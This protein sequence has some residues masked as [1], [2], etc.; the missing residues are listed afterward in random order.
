MIRIGTGYDVH[1]L[2]EN[3]PLILGGVKIKYPLGLLGHSDADVLVHAIMDALLGA[4]ALGDI[5]KHFPDTDKAYKDCDS[6]LLLKKVAKLVNEKDYV[7]NNIDATIIAEKPKLAPHIQAMI[8]NIERT[9]NLSKNRVSVKVTT[10]EGLGFTGSQQGI[11]A[12]AV[13]SLVKGEIIK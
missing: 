5:G 2:V 8:E 9:L 12:H 13:V 11:A 6:L 10:E 4:L 1:R 7:I 3:R